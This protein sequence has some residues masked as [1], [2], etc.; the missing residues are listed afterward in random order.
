MTVIAFDG[1][2]LAA[3]KRCSG[4]S[5]VFTVRKIDR[6]SD[7]SLVGLTGDTAYCAQMLAWLRDGEKLAD[8]PATQ[9][10]REKFAGVL[11][12]RPT[13]EVWK[14]EDTPHPYRIEDRFYAIGSGRDFALAAM[15][16]G[17]SAR[18]AVKVACEFD[19]SCGN[20]VDTLTLL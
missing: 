3:D 4:G 11:V 15:M 2:T 18:E 19:A 16:L 6:L 17:K 20:G 14:Y 5:A 12:V 10:D 9:R 8:F 7:G 1:M 13:G